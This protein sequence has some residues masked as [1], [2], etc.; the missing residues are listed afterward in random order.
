MKEQTYWAHN[1]KYEHLAA[2]LR[3]LIPEEGSVAQPRKNPALELFRKACN[4]YYDLYNNGLC[5]RA[6]EFRGVFKIASGHHK[7]GFGRYSTP[8]YAATEL[9]MDEIV[10][11]AAAEQGLVNFSLLAG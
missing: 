7:R 3:A 4:C 10:L 8:L 5:N 9:R 2:Q 6:Q 1:G 11:N